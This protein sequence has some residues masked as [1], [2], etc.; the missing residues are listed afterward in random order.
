[1]RICRG[2]GHLVFFAAQ[3]ALVASAQDLTCPAVTPSPGNN[4]RGQTIVKGNF[5]YRDLT[6][7]D[8]SNAT[9]VAPYFAYANLTNA[10]FQGAVFVSDNSNAAMVTDFSFANLQK[11]CFIGARFEGLAY[12]TDSTLTCA[13]FSKTDLSK[14]NVIFGASLSFD[15]ART[16]CRMA[17]RLAAMDCE[18]L[19]DWRFLD[20]GGAD[21]G[22][23]S[24]QLSGLDFSSAKLNDVNLAG[25]NLNGTKFI[26]ANLNGA[27]L[28]QASLIG[29]DLSY[30]TLLGAHL[31]RAN[32]TNATFY[33]AFLSN[34]NTSGIT[35][36]ASVKQSRLKNVNLSF[37]QLN[38]VDF[39]Y[40][41]FYGDNPAGV[42]IC[43]TAPSLS[44]CQ[45]SASSDEEPNAAS[46]E[47]FACSCATAHAAR[48]AKTNFRGAYLYGVD[49]TEAQIQ[50][51]DFQEAVVTGANL[52]GATIRSDSLGNATTFYRAFL[53]GTNLEGAQI[54]NRATLTSAFVDFRPDGNNIFILLDGENHNQFVCSDC[55]PPAR[56][57]VCVFVNYP[58][59]TRVP[60]SGAQF[61]CPDHISYGDCGPPKADG[62]N[63]EWKSDITD[64]ASPPTG[65]P[66][67]WYESDSTY[68]KAPT[69]PNS[70]C[71]G[72]PP[73]IFW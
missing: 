44:D 73:V 71:N 17:F 2:V 35:N 42:G 24:S 20:L 38:G 8:F 55:N 32:L 23:C 13:D 21:I 62:S 52:N 9:L 59:P 15:R 49:F 7:A 50:G 60:P 69:N 40:A 12:F 29:A 1:M 30:A 39:T 26:R 72:E 47:G 41:N 67:A 45:K 68:I 36:S 53:Q 19:S 6:G 58:N 54:Q 70:V 34:D 66:P 37:A 64:L 25:A 43:R 56:S 22:A 18:F 27:N 4:F 11:T 5:S 57:N 3:L 46:Y 65:V 61:A 63:P 10:N 16:D 33:Y 14:Q 48:L 28:N 31:D 51:T